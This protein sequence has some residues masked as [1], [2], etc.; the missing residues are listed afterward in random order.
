MRERAP[1][2]TGGKHMSRQ[3]RRDFRRRSARLDVGVSFHAIQFE[4]VDDAYRI[5]IVIDQLA[6][7]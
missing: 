3:Y 6:V 7:Q 1:E 2:D 5:V 4:V